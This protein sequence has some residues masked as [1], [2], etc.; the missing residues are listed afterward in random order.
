MSSQLRERSWTFLQLELPQPGD[1]VIADQQIA[2]ALL[3]LKNYAASDECAC[4][5]DEGNEPTTP[6][7]RC[8]ARE[9]LG[10]VTGAVL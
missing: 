8:A 6:C 1:L 7:R 4:R 3:L 9:L 10:H 5:V 2:H